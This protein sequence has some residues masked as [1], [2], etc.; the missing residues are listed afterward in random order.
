MPRSEIA[1]SHGS[2]I[3]SF[4]RTLHTVFCSGSTQA[5]SISMA[6]HPS[7][8]SLSSFLHKGVLQEAWSLKSQGKE[9]HHV[10]QGRQRR[11]TE[12]AGNAEDGVWE[13]RAW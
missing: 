1:G 4:S 11:D 5:F 7:A 8:S 2:S 13:E 9:K 3:F 10:A 12:P 6:L